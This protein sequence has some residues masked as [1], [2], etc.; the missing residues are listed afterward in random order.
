MRQRKFSPT[1]LFAISM[2][3]CAL[4]AAP[5][6]ADK[7]KRQ[8]QLP[9]SSETPSIEFH[10]PY[11]LGVE[12]FVLK[13]SKQLFKIHASAECPALNG[14]K[15]TRV[16]GDPELVD[17]RGE[18]LRA[19]PRHMNFRVTATARVKTAP[20]AP[21]DD[22]PYTLSNQPPLEELLRSL[23]FRVK[24]FRGIHT[25]TL[26]PTSV[27]MIGVPADVPYNERIYEMKFDL[28][29]VPPDDKIVLE[30]L[31]PNGERLSKF[32]LN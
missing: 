7:H 23:S 5:L 4:A 26:Q 13:P 28:G 6:P 12:A 27:R 3:M 16:S 2:V 17:D 22:P 31:A 9:Q 15:L 8:P 20:V 32:Q 11:P 10:S 19:F 24:I 14:V 1:L 30:V 29:E 18:R 21:G 25:R